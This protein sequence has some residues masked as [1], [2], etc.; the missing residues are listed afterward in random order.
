MRIAPRII[1]YTL[2]RRARPIKS[3]CAITGPRWKKPRRKSPLR[4][5][6][7]WPRL[8]SAPLEESSRG[9]EKRPRAAGAATP[10]LP[11]SN[12]RAYRGPGGSRPRG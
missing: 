2:D 4:P 12:G 7:N 3:E 8:L 6:N 9:A 11:E 10:R 5:R 1:G